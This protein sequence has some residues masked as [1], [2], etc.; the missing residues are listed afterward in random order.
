VDKKF[1]YL[2]F[3]DNGAPAA[4]AFPGWP[5]TAK[6]LRVLDPCCGSGHFLVAA[7][8]ILLDFRM[9][10]EGL[11]ESAAGDAVLRDNLFGLDIDQ[12]CTQIAAFA[13]ALAAWKRGE[14][15]ILPSLNIAC[16]GI[17]V[18]QKKET[19]MRLAEKSPHRFMWGQLYDLFKQAPDLGSLIDPKHVLTGTL[20]SNVF[21]ELQDLLAEAMSSEKDDETK[22][23]GVAAQ[24]IA[25]AAELLTGLYHLV[26]TNV[27]YLARGK[28]SETIA[29]FCRDNYGE[30][31]ADLATVFVDRA[32]RFC[33]TGGSA[34]LVT[35]QNWLFLYSYKKLRFRYLSEYSWNFVAWLGSG[36]FDTISGSVVNVALLSITNDIP[37]INHQLMTL[38]SSIDVGIENKKDRLVSFDIHLSSQVDQKSNVESRILFEES[39]QQ[40][41]LNAYVTIHEGL[42]RGD[43]ARFDRCFWELHDIDQRLWSPMIN[44]P[45]N[46]LPYDGRELVIYW[47][48]GLG[49]LASSDQARITG[50]K[51][52]GKNGVFISRTSSL[53]ST[54]TI[55]EIHAQNG[56]VL[57]PNDPSYLNVLWAFCTSQVFRDEIRK[58]DKKII[59]ASGVLLHIPFDF[60]YWEK[61]AKE[62]GPL[63]EPYSEDPTQWLF[64]GN[65]VQSIAPLQVAVARLIGF[66]WP[67]QKDNK[68]AAYTDQDGI[69]CLPSVGGERQAADRLRDLLV[70]AYN[71]AWSPG[72]LGMLLAD[73]EYG[74]MTLTDWLRDGFFAQH[75]KV[76]HQ[77]PFI[78]HVWDGRKDGFS[79]LVNYH[80]LDKALLERLTYSILGDWI[81]R[82]RHAMGQQEAGSDAR[83]VAALELQ[84]KLELILAGESPYDIFVRWKPL[85]QQPIGWEPDL[86]DGVRLN[87][88]PF[89]TADILR[90]RPNIKWGIDRGKN[91]P[92]APWGEERDNE[93]HL[94]LADKNRVRDSHNG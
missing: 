12:R 67:E 64:K 77:R 78:W 18:G 81:A 70:A 38:D 39:I 72:T 9:S 3:L 32:M 71:D 43:T 10:E 55:G 51:A 15:R 23:I 79:A 82:Q 6:E 83:L 69:I 80:K 42:S 50:D 73:V 88:R 33:V 31:K 62:T 44:S 47:E 48:E 74:G 85:K 56:V 35:P 13:L 90:S 21:P 45:Q 68:L 84:K 58:L 19:W 57:I 17:P 25:K 54:L 4:G 34:V 27:P 92:G 36:A 65:P 41:R 11:S 26:A 59:I 8:D 28:Q 24:G 2:R 66:R 46:G 7:F 40:K 53:R 61:I 22:V 49:E 86:N 91:P 29:T 75:C 76:F 5:R 93:R 20:Y 94:T 89:M 14:Y 87:I 30:G 16:S 60:N 52:W 1:P 37:S 63:P